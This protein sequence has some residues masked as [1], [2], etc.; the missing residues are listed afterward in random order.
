MDEWMWSASFCL[1]LARTSLTTFTQGSRSR[2]QLGNRFQG[3]QCR[4]GRACA[5]GVEVAG[6]FSEEWGGVRGLLF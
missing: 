1:A 4:V 5:Q 2:M 3:G 6:G